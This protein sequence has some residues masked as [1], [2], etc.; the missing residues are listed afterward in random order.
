MLNQERRAS[1]RHPRGALQVSLAAGILALAVG[2]IVFAAALS[3]GPAERPAGAEAFEREIATLRSA[4]DQQTE[5]LRGLNDQYRGRLAE[6]Q[7]AEG[8]EKDFEARVSARS[9]E[10]EALERNRQAELDK[11]KASVQESFNKGKQEWEQAKEI[12]KANEEKAHAGERLAELLEESKPIVVTIASENGPVATGFN[13]AVGDVGAA[14]VTSKYAVKDAGKILVKFKYRSGDVYRVAVCRGVVRYV[15]ESSG[16][17]YLIPDLSAARV[18]VK[19]QAWALD[20]VDQANAG[21]GVYTIGTQVMGDEAFEHT[22]QD[23]S[24][25]NTSREFDGQKYLQL[26][27]PAN[28]GT[29]GAPIF[30][31][32][33]KLVGVLVTALPGMEKTSVA[34][35]AKELEGATQRYLVATG[36]APK[37]LAQAAQPAR[38]PPPKAVVPAK[39]EPP[40][41]S[42]KPEDTIQDVGRI[43]LLHAGPDNL[44]VMRYFGHSLFFRAFRRGV[45]EPVWKRDYPDAEFNILKGTDP[46]ILM[47]MPQ[48]EGGDAYTVDLTTGKEIE[49]YKGLTPRGL[50]E[51]SRYIIK[52]GVFVGINPKADVIV[53]DIKS[54][55]RFESRIYLPQ[56]LLYRGDAW[57][58]NRG[59][60]MRSI[61]LGAALSMMRESDFLLRQRESITKNNTGTGGSNADLLEKN[62]KAQKAV[63]ER[64]DRTVREIPFALQGG[65]SSMPIQVGDTEVFCWGTCIYKVGKDS[66][67][68]IVTNEAEA[69]SCYGASW[70]RQCWPA[71]RAKGDRFVAG[72]NDAA[73]A[74]TQT[75]LF[76]IAA[77]KVVAELPFPTQDSIFL[78]DNRTIALYDSVDRQIVFLNVD[79]LIKKGLPKPKE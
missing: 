34:I 24:I 5:R 17:A 71:N 72:S 65:F 58:G 23:G 37:D 26:D 67:D 62:Q 27:L 73:Y 16:L 32:K 77:N 29:M 79:D 6:I 9:K 25:A 46:N 12:L 36:Q 76:D 20:R 42:F 55:R 69:H 33:G 19:I 66:C 22:V 61:D 52:D 35:P 54:L 21:D 15:D 48:M 47:V 50:T 10:V 4:V 75:H 53:V 49:R 51:Y 11:A 64:F 41:P 59:D 43:L 1:R 74:I 63:I 38:R 30:T 28:E 44:L 56:L 14:I 7:G 2:A 31:A 40:K 3:R 18:S 57:Y 78:S 70:Y 68:C 13:F 60:V 45:K 39:A 8:A